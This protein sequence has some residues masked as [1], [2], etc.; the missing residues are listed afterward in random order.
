MVVASY[1]E[2]RSPQHCVRY[3][4]DNYRTK[5][6]HRR[7]LPL[8]SETSA[9]AVSDLILQKTSRELGKDGQGLGPVTEYQEEQ[10][11]DND[12]HIPMQSKMMAHNKTKANG[13]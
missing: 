2:L 6:C 9:C 13:S 5:S 12:Q 4:S 7:A 11:C 3:R 1:Q 8:A 10:V